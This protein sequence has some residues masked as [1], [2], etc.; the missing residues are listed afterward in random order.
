MIFFII[1][2]IH[3]SFPLK[4][5][6]YNESTSCNIALSQSD[7]S[8]RSINFNFFTSKDLD[9][10]SSGQRIEF[11][12]QLLEEAPLSVEKLNKMEQLYNLNANNN[13]EIKC[14]WIRLGLKGKWMNAV[15][16]AVEMVTEQGRMKFLRPIYR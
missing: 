10:L 4:W 3:L 1:I 12:A 7:Q 9:A 2:K 14:K 16:R 8:N 11:L 13:S 5:T 15:P 6:M